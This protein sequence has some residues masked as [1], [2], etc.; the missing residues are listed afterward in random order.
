MNNQNKS[1]TN[2]L[3][4]KNSEKLYREL[5]EQFTDQEL[6]EGYV[7]PADLEEQEKEAIEAEFRA[8]RFKA[9][10]ERTEEQRLL[11]AL[12][13]IKLLIKDYFES[14]HFDQEFSFSHQ[15]EQYIK[16]IGR[17]QKDFAAEIDLH[18][19][20]LS[21]ILN[22]RDNPNNELVYRLEK[23]CGNIIPAI[24]WWRLYAKQLEDEIKTNDSQRNIEWGKVKNNLMF[25]A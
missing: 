13:R 6:V 2:T 22:G 10:K 17:S 7:F 14:E 24:Y 11:S 19:T 21:R 5:S 3:E 15:L 18:P 4:M 12:M 16:L 8:L 25:R 23:H 20:K 1:L 9:L